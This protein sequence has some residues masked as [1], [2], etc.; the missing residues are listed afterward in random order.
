MPIAHKS[1]SLLAVALAGLITTAAAPK[2]GYDASIALVRQRQERDDSVAVA[3][4]RSILLEHA[5]RTARVF[6]LLHGFSDAPTQFQEL[7]E[8]LFAGGDN[9]YIPRLPHHAERAGRVRALG[10]T[11]AGELE[12]FGDSTID[13]AAGLGDSIV[14]VGL[15]A[16][17]NVAASVAQRR[18]EVL[19]AVLIAPAFAPGRVSD[20]LGHGIVQAGA[21]LPNITRS[22]KP[23]T[24]RP[25][26]I[27]GIS[28]RGLAQVLRLGETI[29]QRAK[30]SPAAAKQIA[31]L[32]N[33]NDATVSGDVAVE[34][35]REW[36]VGPPL[37]SVY[38]FPK[39]L[40]LPH[41]VLERPGHGGNPELV[42]PIVEAL[43]LGARVPDGVK[44]QFVISDWNQPRPPQL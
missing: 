43:A 19:R 10:L 29:R 4:A 32:L 39:S 41:N 36:T 42:F 26:F 25:E 8:R 7:G 9:V 23:D 24:T 12:A 22:E 18:T 28:T 20:D 34:V 2:P 1:T 11:T 17:G 13:I 31:F 16:G 35:A 21:R 37:V 5:R 3:G 33:L 6:V 38:Q 27:Q 40:N 15:S 44:Y 30:K 14:V